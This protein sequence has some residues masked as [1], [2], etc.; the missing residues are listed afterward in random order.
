MPQK[1]SAKKRLRQTDK[2]NARNRG[3]RSRMATA[4]RAAREAS[5]EEREAALK[6]A[7]SIIDRAAKAG[8]IK[9]ETAGRKK[10]KL[11]KELRGAA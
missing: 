10:S 7:V 8:A 1:K 2:R 9:K 4:V 3:I 11:A 5:P 6:R